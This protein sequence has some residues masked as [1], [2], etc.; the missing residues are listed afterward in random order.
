M[1][2]LTP[3]GYTT[4]TKP[5]DGRKGGGVAVFCRDQFRCS[6]PENVSYF[7]SF[8]YFQL[9][10]LVKNKSFSLFPGIPTRTKHCYYEHIFP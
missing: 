8:E 10:V 3:Y 7:Q 2:L 4:F 9:Y 1:G 6:I 5:R